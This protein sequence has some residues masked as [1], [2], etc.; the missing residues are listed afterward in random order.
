MSNYSG[1]TPWHLWVV[2][3][4][5]LL[6]NAVGLYDYIMILELNEAYFNAQN[7]GDAHLAYFTDYPLLPRIF[8][9]TGIVS[10][11]VAPILLLLRIRWTVW[12]AFISA[13]TRAC[14]AVITFGF[15]NRWDV[16]GPWLSLFDIS[17]L[18]MT[19]GFY[20]YCRRMAARGVLR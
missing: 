9:T 17:I 6:L 7:W 15:M 20:L 12:L 13:T 10:G 8:W 19:V 11:V 4:F 14:L 1:K 3:V 18:L 16:F 2:A 5:F